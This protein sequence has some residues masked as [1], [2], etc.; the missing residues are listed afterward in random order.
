MFDK[1]RSCIRDER[2][3]KRVDTGTQP[4]GGVW[5]T[6]HD[7]FCKRAGKS[8]SFL[9]TGF[10]TIDSIDIQYPRR[11]SARE[12]IARAWPELQQL[13]KDLRSGFNWSCISINLS[14]LSGFPAYNSTK[15]SLAEI[16]TNI[17][18]AC[19]IEKREIRQNVRLASNEVI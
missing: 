8:C 4:S 11:K 15:F 7:D 3:M 14:F 5:V 13:T 18:I 10:Q 2:R 1:R 12:A 9:W 19:F 6:F 16:W 17:S